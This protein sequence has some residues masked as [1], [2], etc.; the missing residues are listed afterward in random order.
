[1]NNEEGVLEILG[2]PVPGLVR[3]AIYV[4]LTETDPTVSPVLYANATKD[5]YRDGS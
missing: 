2:N 3:V 1:M 5:T 4:R